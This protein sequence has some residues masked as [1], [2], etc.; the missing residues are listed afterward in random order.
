MKTVCRALGIVKK[1]TTIIQKVFVCYAF[2]LDRRLLNKTVY[3][4]D[5]VSLLDYS[6]LSFIMSKSY[7]VFYYK[8]IK[9]IK[10]AKTNNRPY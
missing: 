7:S 9:K 6:C 5:D 2:L 8:S 10:N 1:I 3:V 4:A